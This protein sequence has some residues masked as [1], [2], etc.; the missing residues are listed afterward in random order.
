MIITLND[1]KNFLWQWDVNQY[2]EVT[3]EAK[4]VHFQLNAQQDALP[5]EV[6]DGRARIP[7][8]LLQKADAEVRCYAYDGDATITR[9]SFRVQVRPKPPDYAYEP[10]EPDNTLLQKLIVEYLEEN[11]PPAGPKGDTGDPGPAGPKGDTGAQGP[12]GDTGEIGPQGPKG[13]TGEPGPAG[14]KGDTG[15]QGPA[16]PKGDT[17][18]Q[19]PAGPKGDPGEMGPQGPKGDTG[20]KGADGTMTFEDLTPEQKASLKGDTGEP[21]PVGPKGDTGEQ[22]PAGPRG[23]TG[24]PGPAGPKGDTGVS[25]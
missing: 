11:P 3:G 7:D 6:K 2:L 13:D 20:P 17:G 23:D 9:Y 25:E 21:G 1:G 5:V 24:E 10:T 4:Q 18:E 22:G 16:G 8:E 12:K 19:G 15:A 14:P